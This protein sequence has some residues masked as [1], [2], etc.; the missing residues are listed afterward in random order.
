MT[1]KKKYRRFP[2]QIRYDKSHPTI[3]F[4]VRTE[5][6]APIREMAEQEGKTI[7]ELVREALNKDVKNKTS[8]YRAGYTTGHNDGYKK[9][10]R[11]H[12]IWYFC[13]VCGERVDITPN[14]DSHKDIIE[15]MKEKRWGHE[16]CHNK[17]T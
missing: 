15:M 17:Q 6:Y 5:E 9:A 11:E 1:Q 3:S 4:R 16:S 14:S 13:C 2:S 12:Q 8:R 7:G 10:K